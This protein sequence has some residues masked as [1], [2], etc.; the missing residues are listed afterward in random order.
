M[1]E[2]ARAHWQLRTVA[3]SQWLIKL[4]KVDL[5]M[6]RDP[7]VWQTVSM[8]INHIAGNFRGRKL[9]WIGEKYDFSQERTF[10]QI[11]RFCQTKGCHY[12]NFVENFF[13]YCHKTAKFTKVFSLES[14]PLYG[15]LTQVESRKHSEDS[16]RVVLWNTLLA[17]LYMYLFFTR[18]NAF[19][20]RCTHHLC[21]IRSA[22]LK[23]YARYDF[24]N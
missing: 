23:S 21:H 1:V 11:A 2:S 13:A 24:R 19:T 12:P 3:A 8:I 5:C 6:Q 15:M 10:S 9:S 22:K 16:Y 14:F 18:Q 4:P 7:Q 20:W 17:G